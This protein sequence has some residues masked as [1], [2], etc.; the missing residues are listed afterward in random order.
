MAAWAERTKGYPGKIPKKRIVVKGKVK[1][2]VKATY[3]L[4]P[5]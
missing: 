5:L 3:E 1:A 2:E 4:V